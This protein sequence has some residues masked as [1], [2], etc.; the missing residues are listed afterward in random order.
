MKIPA[1]EWQRVT[2]LMREFE[3]LDAEDLLRGRASPMY[4]ISLAELGDRNKRRP[5]PDLAVGASRCGGP[6]DLPPGFTWPHFA[7]GNPLHFYLQLDLASLPR[8]PDSPLPE[9]GLLY[10]F[11]GMTGEDY[12]L[13]F[14]VHFSDAPRSSL[15]RQARPDTAAPDQ[16]SAE[17]FAPEF[18]PHALQATVG[19][20]IAWTLDGRENLLDVLRERFPA[21]NESEF[22]DRVLEFQLRSAD[23]NHAAMKDTG[24]PR[25]WWQVATL[26]GA[27]VGSQARRS[28]QR[29]LHSN[30]AD[31]NDP[32]L[33]EEHARWRQFLQL[34]S[35]TITGFES[36]CDARPYR[37]LLRAPASPWCA[38]EHLDAQVAGD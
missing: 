35:N 29:H 1:S 23:V 27:T 12:A 34:E 32:A 13:S 31:R 5:L 38:F 4:Q 20:E 28:A 9:A 8:L 3:L 2:G 10:V 15:Q 17:Y 18:E 30:G 26:L 11:F 16:L 37:L 24:Y 36:L 22:T 14:R 25:H 7:P 19:T 21:A 33:D 6:P